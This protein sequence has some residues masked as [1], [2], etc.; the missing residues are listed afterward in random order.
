M[1]AHTTYRGPGLLHPKLSA[2]AV[3][4]GKTL[5]RAYETKR[6]QF[7]FEIFET[8]RSPARQDYL[9]SRKTTK[10]GKWQSAHQ[11][12]LAVDFVPY[13]TQW[14]AAAVGGKAG[15]FWPDIGDECWE[16]LGNE[17]QKFGLS[18][19][20]RWD[21]SHVEHPLFREIMKTIEGAAAPSQSG[22]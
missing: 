7:R 2:S 5:V 3:S 20:Y 4:L 17:A 15:W 10:A 19:P 16:F 8:F 18:R 14:E 11:F 22:L 12:G 9:L 6:T 21:G 1:D 13:L